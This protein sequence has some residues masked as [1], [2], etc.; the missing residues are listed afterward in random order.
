MKDRSVLLTAIF[1]A[2]A[3]LSVLFLF[4]PKNEAKIEQSIELV[5]LAFENNSSISSEYTCDGRDSF[6]AFKVSAPCKYIAVVIY[7]PD[8]PLGT[9][10][11]FAAYNIPSMKEMI[12]NESVNG[13]VTENDFGVKEYR[14]PCPPKGDKPHRY[15]IEVYCQKDVIKERV[16][17]ARKL[18]KLLKRAGYGYNFLVFRYARK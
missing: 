6:P 15:F 14:G 8:A 9:F 18:H 12:V 17:S 4:L 13:V 3:L 2:I 10:Y 11:H 7:D 16:E 1:L 5:P